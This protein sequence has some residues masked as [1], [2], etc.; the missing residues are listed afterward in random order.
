MAIVSTYLPMVVQTFRE[1]QAKEKPA[2]TAPAQAG[3]ATAAAAPKEAASKP[4]KTES[5]GL[6]DAILGIGA[7]LLL[8]AAL[9]FLAGV[10]NLLGLLIIGFG[11]WE[12]WKLNKRTDLS[13]SGPYQVGAAP[14]GA[15]PGS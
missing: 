7:L 1:R 5:V 12:A 2:A 4:S 13:I 10:K 6:G 15:L 11:L 9:P 8:V 3:G 14:A